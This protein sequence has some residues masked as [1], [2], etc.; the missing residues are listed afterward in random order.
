MAF[1]GKEST[2]NE[3][4]GVGLQEIKATGMNDQNQVKNVKKDVAIKKDSK[5]DSF[6]KFVAVVIVVI[7]F[8]FHVIRGTREGELSYKVLISVRSLFLCTDSMLSLARRTPLNKLNKYVRPECVLK[9]LTV[10]FNELA[11]LR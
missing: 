2:V 1:E 10:E 5:Y 3:A 6:C 8:V 7:S 4:E 11:V 9:L